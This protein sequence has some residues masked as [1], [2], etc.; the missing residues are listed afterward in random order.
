[1]KK[2]KF[3]GQFLGARIDLPSY[4]EQLK[5]AMMH[6]LHEAADAWLQA[7]LGKVPLWSGM[8]RG[9]LLELSELVNGTVVLTPLKAKSRIPEGKALGTAIEE[10]DNDRVTITIKTNVP[11]YNLQ[12]Y[13]SSRS[14]T[15]P[16]QSL[17]AGASA[18]NKSVADF[19]PVQVKLKPVKV[20]VI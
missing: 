18:F 7:V 8:A 6:R 19:K 10:I 2:L 20:K 5:E 1:L 12:E 17:Q 11:H 15:S 3:Y 4:R 14:P 16:W 9:S 13:S